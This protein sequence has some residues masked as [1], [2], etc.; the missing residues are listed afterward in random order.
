MRY[1][2]NQL[3]MLPENEF[4]EYYRRYVTYYQG[5][6]DEQKRAEN[7][8]ASI[9]KKWVYSEKTARATK[10]TAEFW[11]AGNPFIFHAFPAS[12]AKKT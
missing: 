7:Q 6:T 10:H 2:A 4:M 12:A 9:V 8:Y 11:S 5:L 1:N 3:S